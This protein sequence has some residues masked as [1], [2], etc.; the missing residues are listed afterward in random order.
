APL[1]FGGRL[2]RGIVTW[3][4][5]TFN[6]CSINA[7]L[8]ATGGLSASDEAGEPRNLWSRNTGGKPPV[9]PKVPAITAN[10][11]GT[12]IM[13]VVTNPSRCGFPREREPVLG[14]GRVRCGESPSPIARGH[15]GHQ[16]V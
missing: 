10:N 6:C 15:R 4:S 2:V 5:C 11:R 9:A 13:G 12:A 16:A 3:S 7:S 1:K 8:G 14:P